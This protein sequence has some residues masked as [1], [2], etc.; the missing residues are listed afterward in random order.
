MITRSTILSLTIILTFSMLFILS[1]CGGEEEGVAEVPPVQVEIQKP[2]T[3]TVT[4]WH[5]TTCELVS[6][7]DTKLSFAT[8]GRIIELAAREGDSVVEGQYLGRVDTSTL[9]ARYAGI[10]SQAESTRSQA[11]AADLAADAASAQVDL[12]RIASNQAETDLARFESLLADGVATRSEYENVKLGY[13]TAMI[14]LEGA[15]EQAGAA[16]AQAT[17]AYDGVDAVL[18][19][20]TQIMEMIEDGTL[21]APFS[22]SISERFVDPGT[23]VGAGTPIFK[24]VGEGES[25]ANQIEIHLNV[26]E[27]LAGVIT[28][29]SPITIDLAACDHQIFVPINHLAS[30][31]D[32]ESRSVAAVGYIDKDSECLIPGMFGT[33]LIPIEVHE[34]VMTLPETAVLII[35]DESYVFIATGN[36]ASRRDV[37]TGLREEGMIEIIEGINPDDDVIVTGNTFLLEGASI[38]IR[39]DPSGSPADDNPGTE[40]EQ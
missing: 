21:R 20:G 7:L 11:R 18:A 28:A 17:A 1:G 39:N 26:P 25:V 8:G 33:A 6:P 35:D 38:E 12:A 16:R 14:T 15:I 22:G 36:T 10:L 30:E 32:T 13:D 27:T 9:S 19:Q 40:D 34:N 37:I 24:L 4:N 23:M 2:V 5:R 3:G 29:G 31:V